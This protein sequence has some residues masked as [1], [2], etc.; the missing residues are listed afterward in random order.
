MPKYNPNYPLSSLLLMYMVVCILKGILKQTL[1]GESKDSWCLLFRLAIHLETLCLSRET[2]PRSLCWQ[3]SPT[4]GLWA[5]APPCS[6]HQPSPVKASASILPCPAWRLVR[7]STEDC[8]VVVKEF[9]KSKL[10]YWGN[11]TS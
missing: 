6:C 1:P 8:W 7:P 5:C 11:H 9:K 2:L 3:Q 10:L 4:L